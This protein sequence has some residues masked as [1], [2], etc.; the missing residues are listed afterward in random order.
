MFLNRMFLL[1]LIP[2]L[3]CGA[4]TGFAQHVSVLP[5]EDLLGRFGITRMWWSQATIDPSR[6]RVAFL[7]VDE[8]NVY[9]QT[10]GGAVTAFDSESGKRLWSA[11]LGRPDQPRFALTTNENLALVVSGTLIHAVDRWTGELM[12]RVKVPGPPSTSPELDSRNVYIGTIDGSIYAL[13]LER[14]EALWDKNRLPQ[15]SQSAV[16]WRYKTTRE[17]SVPPVSNGAMVL[18][19]SGSGSGARASALYS[20]STLRRELRFQF[21]TNAPISAPLAVI[22]EEPAPGEDEPTWFVYMASQDFNVYC[23]NAVTGTLRWEFISGMPIHLA[24]HVIDEQLFLLPSHGGL[25][26]LAR[27]SGLERWWRAEI[28]GF[29]AATPLHVYASDARGNL[30]TLSREDGAVV[31]S[32]PLRQFDVRYA[33]AVTDRMFL[34]TSTGLVMCLRESGRELPLYHKRPELRPILPDFAPETSEEP[35]GEPDQP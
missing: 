18:A 21:E 32:F 5:S 1:I 7:V 34:A 23:L 19:A 17:V 3:L 12:W 10:K 8:E 33:N 25:F 30:V 2:V 29:V 31:G 4:Q 9:V 20:I 27:R 24:P 26:C 15:W 35:T 16:L 6:D 13:S 14:I 11:Q 28:T 22:Q